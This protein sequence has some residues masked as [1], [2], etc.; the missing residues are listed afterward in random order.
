ML[1]SWSFT[2][3]LPYV[4]YSDLFLMHWPEASGSSCSNREMRA[5]TWKALEELYNEGT[6]HVRS[7]QKIVW[8]Q[9]QSGILNRAQ[10][11]LLVPAGVC[12]AIGV[13]NFLVRHLEQLKEDCSVVPHVNQVAFVLF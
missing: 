9:W 6:T 7:C 13:S 4:L 1:G 5:E 11:S 8:S 12:R 2:K 3:S 10:V